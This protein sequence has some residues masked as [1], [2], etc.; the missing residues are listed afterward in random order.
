[1]RNAAPTL[2]RYHPACIALLVVA[3]LGGAACA[4]NAPGVPNSLAPAEPREVQATAAELTGDSTNAG[5]TTPS[6]TTQIPATT[7]EVFADGFRLPEDFVVPTE[8]SAPSTSQALDPV[9][10]PP[11]VPRISADPTTL[12]QGILGRLGLNEAVSPSVAS[13]PVARAGTAPLTGLASGPID[14]AP[15]VIKI[16]NSGKARPQT[17]LHEA[18]LIFEEEVEWGITRLAAVFHT[19]GGEVG[20]VRS[21]RTTDISYLSALGN[22]VL[23]YSGANEVTEA[24]LGAQERVQNL[25]AN[26]FGGYWRGAGRSAPHNLY[27]STDQLWASARQA[28]TPAQFAYR[29]SDAE[30]AGSPADGATIAFPSNR[31]SW[32]WSGDRWLREQ[33]GAAHVTTDGAQLA[34]A[35]VVV[36]EVAEVPTGLKDSAGGV[37]PEYVYVGTGPAT[38]FSDGK[39]LRGVWT[40]PTLADVATLTRPDGR[41]IELTPGVTW[42]EIVTSGALTI[43]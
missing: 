34:A 20:P 35:N 32:T 37:V 15:I 27:T 5:P 10:P 2:R 38:V 26:R 31:V 6:P 11:T 1:M 29:E 36:V 16:D 21:G 22:P 4:N 13:A 7:V 42:V 17:G 3:A 30:S 39:V 43:R 19:A 41:V 28:P 40:R 12:Y 23:A 25:G 14:R 33:G 18:D 9:A 8:P 24:L